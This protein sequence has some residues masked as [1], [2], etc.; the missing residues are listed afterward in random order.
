M[1]SNKI[2]SAKSFK[3]EFNFGAWLAK[4]YIVLLILINTSSFGQQA[5]YLDNRNPIDTRVA[6][7]ISKL[8]LEEKISLLGY[9]NKAIPRLNIP[10]YNWWNEGLHGVARAGRAT[11]F[12]QA[13]GMAA[14]FNKDLLY[15]VANVISTEARAKHNLAVAEDNRAQY[16][17]LSFWSPNI[18]IFRDPRWGRGQETYGEDPYLTSRL[19]AAFVKGMQGTDPN[20][21]K[22]AACAKHY[23]VHSGPENE[24]HSFNAL[25]DQK[26]LR[27]TYLPAFKYLVQNN[28]ESVMG[29]Y[30]RVNGEPATIGK[31]LIDIL[32]NEWGFKGHFLTDCWA[33][34]DIYKTHK[35]LPNSVEVAAAAIKAGVNLDCSELLQDDLLQAVKQRLI[36]EKEIDA[37]LKNLL[38]TQFK[39]GFYD[40]KGSSP[41][42]NYGADSI[43]NAAHV[44]LSRKMAAQS[45]VLLKNANNVLPLQPDKLKKLYVTGGNAS[46]INL[47]LGNYSGISP[48]MVTFVEG[49]VSAVKPTVNV[50]YDYGVDLND[51]TH[52]SGHWEAEGS[53]AIIAV[54]GLT[55]LLEGE[56]GDALLSTSGGD[57]A[58]ISI[59]RS[60]ILFLEKLKRKAKSPVIVVVTGG[61]AVDLA[62]IQPYAD[63]IIMAW[64]PGEQGGNALADIVFGKLSPAGRLPLTFYSSLNDLPAYNNYNME[65]RTYRYF[66]GKPVYPFG[67]GLSYATFGYSWK[68]KP[69]SVYSQQSKSINF[70]IDIK[71]NG[72]M[73]ADEVSQAYIKYPGLE[74]MPLKEL[75][76]FE[77]TTILK[78][79]TRTVEFDIPLDELMKWDLTTNK[80]MLYKGEY[81]V[82]IGGHSNDEK[83]TATFR[84]R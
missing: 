42:A 28:V 20:H 72:N 70:K 36:S 63:A 51:T 80:F 84:I 83:L 11:V 75:K 26:D 71:N 54:V 55:P 5:K 13:I 57:K 21:L 33:L 4:G 78:G 58:D 37:S 23:A 64:Y 6:D 46:S 19:G 17:G 18:N 30:N 2:Q 24:R 74:R 81:N 34:Q 65:G 32:R 68:V 41:F 49:I 77:R 62:A 8:T 53:D 60:H 12:P 31:T 66:K 27:E 16:L 56:E 67:Y 76:S 73:D 22:I 61:S 3:M 9:K 50:A 43:S 48:N 15:Q 1:I 14:S 47:L 44:A 82:F 25:V 29:A 69:L 38:A 39:L 10:A 59:P 45:M 7:L 35:V 40:P 79:D 52:F